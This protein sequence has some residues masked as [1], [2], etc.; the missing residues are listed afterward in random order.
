[1]FN[2]KNNNNNKQA[3][4]PEGDAHIRDSDPLQAVQ[5]HSTDIE[6][7]GEAQIISFVPSNPL[8]PLE[9]E[10]KTELIN[11]DENKYHQPG[12]PLF[13]SS[14]EFKPSA[15]NKLTD[16]MDEQINDD[17]IIIDPDSMIKEKQKFMDH[18]QCI[19]N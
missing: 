6:I 12:N 15:S 5:Q 1:M 4:E 16:D 19:W 2:N 8:E 18:N 10:I 9:Y 14:L 17:V 11:G 3:Q 13:K 7:Q